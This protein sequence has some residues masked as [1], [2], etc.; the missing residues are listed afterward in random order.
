MLSLSL[1][2]SNLSLSASCL[3]VRLSRRSRLSI[4]RVES[5]WSKDWA[6]TWKNRLSETEDTELLAEREKSFF[7]LPENEAGATFDFHA[8]RHTRGAWLGMRGVHPKVI[9]SVMRY[10]TITLTVDTYG[11]LI[12]G[13][14]SAVIQANADMTAVPDITAGAEGF[15]DEQSETCTK[16]VRFRDASECVPGATQC[17]TVSGTPSR[18][19]AQKRPSIAGPEGIGCD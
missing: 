17:E 19:V 11:Q 1:V 16:Y 7:L 5:S 8:L 9:Q 18:K 13:A 10:S 4:Y 3:A 14:E 2:R 12:E 15:A 6:F